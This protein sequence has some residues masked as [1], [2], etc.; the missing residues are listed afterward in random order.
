MLSEEK[1]AALTANKVEEQ[2]ITLGVRPEHITLGEQ[3]VEAEI[4]VHEMMG[5][6]VHLHMNAYGK[7]V[8]AVVSTMD[9]SEAEVAAMK[10]G[11]KVTFDFGGH[12]CHVFNKETGINLEA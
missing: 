7:D 3:G 10:S 6:S 4:D 11:T 1:Q 2:A 8:V 9:M 5:S 12:N